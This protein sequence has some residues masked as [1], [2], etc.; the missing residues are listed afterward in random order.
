MNNTKLLKGQEIKQ[1]TF[2]NIQYLKI[3]SN[4]L[5]SIKTTTI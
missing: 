2:L 5:N 4:K 3:F 1:V